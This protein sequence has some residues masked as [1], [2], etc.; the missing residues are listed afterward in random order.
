MSFNSVH[1]RQQ[2]TVFLWN[3][4][5]GGRREDERSRGGQ[6]TGEKRRGVV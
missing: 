2:S 1:K 4:L 5:F 6:E 3:Y